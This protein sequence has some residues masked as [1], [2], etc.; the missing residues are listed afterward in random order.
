MRKVANLGLKTTYQER[1]GLLV[2]IREMLALRFLPC[3]HIEGAFDQ[4]MQDAR[5]PELQQ[6]MGYLDTTRMNNPYL[7]YRQWSVYQQSVRTNK[8]VDGII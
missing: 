8:D 7:S 4:M 3:S 1:Q 6:L 5:T 2:F